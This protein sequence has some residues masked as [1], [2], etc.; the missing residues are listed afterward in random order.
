MMNVF[1]DHIK[2]LFGTNKAALQ[3]LSFGSFSGTNQF[4]GLDRYHPLTI[5]NLVLVARLSANRCT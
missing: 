3:G 1:S 5:P 4:R 2:S